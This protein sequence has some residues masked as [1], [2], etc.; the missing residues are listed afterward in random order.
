MRCFLLTLFLVLVISA[1]VSEVF[2]RLKF[3]DPFYTYESWGHKK[4]IL[5]G[6]E[7]KE[8]YTWTKDGAVY[9]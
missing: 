6:F 5:F 7:A 8:N 2:L 4:S 3:R 1:T 9:T